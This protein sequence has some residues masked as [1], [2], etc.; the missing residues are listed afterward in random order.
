MSVAQRWFLLQH[1]LTDDLWFVRSFKVWHYSGAL[2]HEI[3]WPVGQELYEVQWQ[4][5]AANTFAA[6]PI[7]A[8]KVAGIT[9]SQP[10]ASTV[11]YRPP[12][13]RGINIPPMSLTGAKQSNNNHNNNRRPQS[14]GGAAAAGAGA[15][16]AAEND[17]TAGGGSSQR[18]VRRADRNRVRAANFRK[19]MENGADNTENGVGGGD[20]SNGPA[21]NQAASPSDAAV[22]GTVVSNGNDNSKPAAQPAV[23]TQ[24]QVIRFKR[25][26]SV[27]KRL[28]DI[29]KLKSRRMKG[30]Q[31]EINQVTK[32][33]SELELQKELAELKLG[34]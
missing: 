7:S 12:G 9:S 8:A 1:V 31:L 32:I 10:V 16:A 2:L 20:D 14:G 4:F 15:G 22:N 34:A 23:F 5:F 13:A 24:E 33:N 3:I 18:I 19:K 6:Q 29:A 17:E 28:N 26:R 11:A 27:T 30:E 21:D 25:I